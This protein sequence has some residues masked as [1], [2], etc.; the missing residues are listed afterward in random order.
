MFFERE[1]G[2]VIE[3]NDNAFGFI[4]KCQLCPI[5]YGVNSANGQVEKTEVL[6]RSDIE[7]EQYWERPTLPI[8]YNS[9]R[10]K[11]K[12]VQ[13]IDPYYVD[14]YLED[15]R[16]REWG[17]RLRGVWFWNYNTI[18][19]K[20][21]CIYITG[22]NYIY[23]T[24]WKFQGKYLDF[25]ITDRD[26]FYVVAYCMEDPNSLGLNELTKR[27]NGKTARIGCWLYERTSRMSNHHGG[28]QSKADDDAWEV[29]KKAV[30]HPWKTLPD[31]FKP[32]YDT[33]KGDD[34]SEELR[35]F[36]TSRRGSKAVDEDEEIEEPLN[37]F[38]DFKPSSEAAYDGPELHSYTSDE[39]GKTKKPVSIIERQNVTRYC[40]EIDGEFKGKHWYTTTVE[41]DKGEEENYEFQEMTTKSNPLIRD[42]NGRTGTGL[43]TYFLPAYRG[44]YF[45]RYGYPD[46]NKAKVFLMNTR[47]KYEEDGDTR[48]LSSF[49]RKNPMTFKEA[50]SADGEMAL[51][52]PEKLNKQ[53]DDILW[54]TKALIE[55]GDLIWKDGYEFKRPHE[56]EQGKF[57]LNQLEWKPNPKGKFEKVVGWKPKDANNVF[58][59]GGIYFP[60]NKYSMR[61]GCDPFKYDK[62]KDKRRSNCAAFAYQIADPTLPDEVYD[63]M[64]VMR[65]SYRESSTHLANVDVLKMAWWCGC[66]VLFERNVDHWK[67]DFAAMQCQGFLMWLPREQEPGIISDGRGNTIQTI[68]N[69]TESYINKFIH[70]VYFKELI[71]KETGW[72]GFKV[73]DTEKFDEPMAAGH[74]LIAVKGVTQRNKIETTVDI[75][76]YFR[77]YKTQTA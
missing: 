35:F 47:R 57:V 45:D 26:L 16:K 74:T 40:S 1:N 64:F 46:E 62:T 4:Y 59:R 75:G 43:Y 15:I 32:R 55:K 52:D 50:F 76:D 30:V 69:Y 23:I 27:K 61:I 77:A 53:L 14:P 56:F 54:A 63:D 66:E 11:E 58:E 68:C 36:A 12:S 8:D 29:F 5:G 22:L 9:R 19:G 72:L 33:M 31:F 48:K 25:R 6:K 65:Y 3:V 39:S 20:S 34:P 7:T 2:S 18:L 21:E 41:P 42:D 28:I 24:Y 71:I 44:M 37:S 13:A 70:K 67:N 38:I 60:N 10:K 73:E 17:R 49:K 51:Y